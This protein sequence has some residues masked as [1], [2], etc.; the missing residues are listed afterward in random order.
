MRVRSCN[1]KHAVLDA[2]KKK[3]SN[4]GEIKIGS[5]NLSR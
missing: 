3:N 2:K 4:K 5:N 1:R